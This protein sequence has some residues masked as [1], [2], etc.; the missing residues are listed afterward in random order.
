MQ[1]MSGMRVSEVMESMPD[2]D[3]PRT[4]ENERETCRLGPVCRIVSDVVGIGPCLLW[5]FLFLCFCLGR[6]YHLAIKV[7]E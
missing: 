6:G 4:P 7:A 5:R 1:Q 2:T 3:P